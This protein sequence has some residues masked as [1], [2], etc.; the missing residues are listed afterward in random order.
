M[1]IRWDS[2][3]VVKNLLMLV[4]A[5]V[6]SGIFA[7]NCFR[8]ADFRNTDRMSL[9]V[10]E[11]LSGRNQVDIGLLSKVGVERFRGGRVDSLAPTMADLQWSPVA[12]EIKPS[13]FNH[14]QLSE[15]ATAGKFPVFIGGRGVRIPRLAILAY[16]PDEKSVLIVDD[17]D[18]VFDLGLADLPTLINVDDELLVL[19]S[20]GNATRPDDAIGGRENPGLYVPGGFVDVVRVR[21]GDRGDY[22]CYVVNSSK[23]NVELTAPRT[24]CGCLTSAFKG[25]LLPA[26]GFADL[27]LSLVVDRRWP[28]DSLSQRLLLT[29]SGIDPYLVGV[30]GTVV[31]PIRA[32]PGVQ[33][34]GVV[35][36][37]EREITWSADLH[38]GAGQ[39]ARVWPVQLDRG[40]VFKGVEVKSGECSL[41]FTIDPQEVKVD[42]AGGF[43]VKAVVVVERGKER[44]SVELGAV[45]RRQPWL[46]AVPTAVYR[47]GSSGD[48]VSGCIRLYASGSQRIEH[49]EAIAWAPGLILSQISTDTIRYEFEVPNVEQPLRTAATIIADGRVLSVPFVCIADE[50]TPNGLQGESTEQ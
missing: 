41:A 40:V 34:C 6:A 43:L 45:G 19:E 33:S 36:A 10:E 23:Q 11:D 22:A 15:F 26:G 5:A 47:T 16:N 29:G 24:S 12:A 35:S 37:G 44:M 42:D 17:A 39:P 50:A 8:S 27:K 18:T 14:R 13:Q 25:G 28:D 1:L 49:C 9:A 38:Y 2:R 46:Q 32:L 30:H 48:R 21:P 31:R 3:H 20:I 7:I 4:V